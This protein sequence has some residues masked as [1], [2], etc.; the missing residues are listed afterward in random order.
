MHQLTPAE[1]DALPPRS[2]LYV[3]IRRTDPQRWAE[4]EGI[5]HLLCDETTVVER[6]QWDLYFP[7]AACDTSAAERDDEGTYRIADSE[8]YEFRVFDPATVE[9]PLGKTPRFA[10]GS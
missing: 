1:L 5:H 6:D 2:E 8:V 9:G 3:W 4:P 7:G 10:D